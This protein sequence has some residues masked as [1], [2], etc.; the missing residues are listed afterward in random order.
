M[1]KYIE[2]QTF[3]RKVV[4]NCAFVSLRNLFLYIILKNDLQ[5]DSLKTKFSTCKL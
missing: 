3:S 1:N 2:N 4:I 5:F